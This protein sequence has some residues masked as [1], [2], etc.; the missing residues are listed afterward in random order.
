MVHDWRVIAIAGVHNLRDY[1]GD[2]VADKRL[3]E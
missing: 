1:G 3:I 2:A